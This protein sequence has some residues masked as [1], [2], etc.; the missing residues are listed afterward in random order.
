MMT[1]KELTA[2]RAED[3]M[4]MVAIDLYNPLI[5]AGDAVAARTFQLYRM[6]RTTTM[7]VRR[8]LSESESDIYM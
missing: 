3:S 4:S 6:S 2:K 8:T 7:K 5:P 1:N